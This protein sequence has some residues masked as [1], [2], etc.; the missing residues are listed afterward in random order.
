MRAA[1]VRKSNSPQLDKPKIKEKLTAKQLEK[2]RLRQIELARLTKYAIETGQLVYFYKQ[3]EFSN[4]EIYD[5]IDKAN[6]QDDELD[7]QIRRCY[8]NMLDEDKD[9]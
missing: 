7:R 8:L 1:K 6:K 2:K 5:A 4:E 9:I 3:R